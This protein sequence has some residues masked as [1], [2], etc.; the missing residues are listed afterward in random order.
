MKK[1]DYAKYLPE[2]MPDSD[3]DGNITLDIGRDAAQITKAIRTKLMRNAS[4]REITIVSYSGTKV[5][6]MLKD[7]DKKAAYHEFREAII[8]AKKR[9]PI[10]WA[11]YLP[12]K[13]PAIDENGMI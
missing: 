11:S 10:N 8:N 3:A 7:T 6:I 12:E 4:L 9:E 2:E 13:M 1:T 5:F